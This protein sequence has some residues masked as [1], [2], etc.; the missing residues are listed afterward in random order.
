VQKRGTSPPLTEPADTATST[1]RR[2]GGP[3]RRLLVAGLVAACVIAADQTSKSWAVSRLSRGDIH[4]FWKLDFILEYNSGSSFSFAQ[5]WAPLIGSF[6]AVL[7]CVM[8]VFVRRTRSDGVAAALG[9]V[10]GG[11]LGNL[12][13]RVFRSHHGAVV[14]FIAFHFWPTFNV[15]DSCI[16]I[17]GVVL[18]IL[19]WRSQPERD[20]SRAIDV[21]AA[22]DS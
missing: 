8:L 4:V 7:V 10:I 14:D 6:A 18:V 9:L 2:R 22:H 19:L 15:A 16:T 1:D 20:P 21:E 3:T 13:D 17:G 5:G 11:A 12:S